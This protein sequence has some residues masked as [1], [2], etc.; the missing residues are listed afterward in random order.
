MTQRPISA[1]CTLLAASLMVS[2]CGS[3]TRRAERAPLTPSDLPQALSGTIGSV[4][5][6]EGREQQLVSG[7]GF[8]VGLNGT[9]GE[10]LNERI[11]ATLEREMSLRGVGQ[12]GAFEGTALEGMSPRQLLRDRNTA[13]VVVQAAIPPGAK[14]GQR[15]DVYVRA[16]NASSL[17]GGRLWTTQL[18]VGQP[19]AIGDPQSTVTA[20]ASGEIF[21]N[22]FAEPGRD[23]SG[24]TRS[25]GR[26]LNGGV[27]LEE[28]TLNVLLNG[29]GSHGRTQQIEAAINSRFPRGRRDREQTARGRD[30]RRVTVR[31]PAAFADRAGRFV[32]IVEH[33][34]IDTSFPQVYAQQY[35]ETLR[36]EPYLGNEMSLALEA[37]G[38]RALPFV[39]DLYDYPE[40]VPR[41]AALR[42]GSGL[43]D[44]VVADHLFEMARSAPVAIRADAI[45]EMGRIEG[46][47]RID[48]VLRDLLNSEELLVRI[49]AYEALA[50]RA[51]RLQ[52]QRLV[53]AEQLGSTGRV[54]MRSFDE[55]RDL[56][57]VAL[58]AG[59]RQGV[60]RVPVEDKFLFDRVI[61]GEPLIYVSQSGRPRVALF[62]SQLKIKRPCFASV[63]SDRL[64]LTSDGPEEPIRLYYREQPPGGGGPLDDSVGRVV[65]QTIGDD[66]TSLVDFMAHR[67]D[68]D[69]PRTGLDLS[70]S[71][72]VG[73][74]HAL[75]R[76][77][78]IDAEFA[79]ERDRLLADLLAAGDQMPVQL[80]PIA[81]GDR[82]EVLVFD[83]EGP[84]AP[85]AGDAPTGS[86]VK[87]VTPVDQR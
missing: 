58:P 10:V 57:S 63:W 51:E 3:P 70:Y 66:V 28:R 47:P 82:Q 87:P 77:G 14:E 56:A 34:K 53:A 73:A 5:T 52:A 72:V 39:R 8:V 44:P 16:I 4:A 61:G 71:E 13:A 40:A 9:G 42:A 1:F 85:D 55:L 68:A 6:I 49:A 45:E 22:P 7:Y 67:P 32:S 18:Q 54:T 17:E 78:V 29:D 48:Q 12:P 35:E 27:A 20:E 38:E 83:E 62:G 75:H 33:M 30:D 2:G 21:I 26:I 79:T 80:R 23:I 11:A 36:E 84:G 31:V 25:V 24:V 50:E 59:T 15:F 86:L 19:A 37:L 43:G 65:T 81:P 46:G 74:L 64:V 76:A 60:S 41:L 69:D